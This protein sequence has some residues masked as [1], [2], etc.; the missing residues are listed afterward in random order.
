[1]RSYSPGTAFP[2]QKPKT[3]SDIREYLDD[4]KLNL[5]YDVLVRMAGAPDGHL[6]PES[7]RAQFLIQVKDGIYRYRFGGELL[8]WEGWIEFR[9]N[10]FTIPITPRMTERQIK[11]VQRAN[12]QLGILREEIFPRKFFRSNP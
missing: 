7:V 2:V 11:I 1:M 10:C 8:D 12:E 6:A 5:I 4:D 9:Y 3:H